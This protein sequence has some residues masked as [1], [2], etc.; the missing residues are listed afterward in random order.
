MA[1]PASLGIAEERCSYANKPAVL[2][3]AIDT[4]HVRPTSAAHP[5][6]SN[7]CLD[8][9][10]AFAQPDTHKSL[11]LTISAKSDLVTVRQKTPMLTGG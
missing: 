8:G 10:G 7:T 3:N 1:A 11:P 6:I 9:A 4:S 2:F 5:A